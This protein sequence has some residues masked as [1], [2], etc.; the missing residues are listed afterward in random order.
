MRREL[1]IEDVGPRWWGKCLVRRRARGV[2]L[3]NKVKEVCRHQGV[4]VETCI[5]HKLSSL[6]VA[7]ASLSR[8]DMRPSGLRLGLL[9]AA[10]AVGQ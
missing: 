3:E 10:A 9:A 1:R 7:H 8:L 4:L 5:S 6:V 2:K